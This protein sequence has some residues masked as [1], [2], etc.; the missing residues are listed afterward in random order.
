MNPENPN[1][2]NKNDRTAALTGQEIKVNPDGEV[3][4]PKTYRLNAEPF[5]MKVTVRAIGTH[6]ETASEHGGRRMDSRPAEGGQS[7]TETAGDGS[8]RGTLCGPLLRGEDGEPHT[9]RIL[10]AKL[11]SLGHDVTELPKKKAEN[12]RGED[13]KFLID[14]KEYVIQITTMPIDSVWQGLGTTGTAETAG[15]FSDAIKLVRTAF[16]NKRN[17]ARGTILAIDAAHVGALASQDVVNAYLREYGDPNR[18]FGFAQTWIVGPT[19]AS[20]FKIG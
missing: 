20:T 9:A 13:R 5:E 18:E 4:K 6:A 8:F 1:P 11:R 16:E 10:A 15:Q 12:A 7:V 2:D 3:G 14:D 17:K 19:Q